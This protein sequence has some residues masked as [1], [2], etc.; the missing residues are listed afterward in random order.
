MSA[1]QTRT[2]FSRKT[3]AIA[4]ASA[5]AMGGVQLTAPT[6]GVFAAATASAAELNPSVVTKTELVSDKSGQNVLGT[7][8]EATREAY[9][10]FY[11]KHG[12]HFTL[13]LDFKIPDSAQPGDTLEVSKNSG[14]F[15]IKGNVEAATDEGRKVGNLTVDDSVVTFTVSN[16][17]AE[18]INRTASF[19]IPFFIFLGDNA[20]QVRSSAKQD[21]GKPASSVDVYFSSKPNSVL[22]LKRV[23]KYESNNAQLFDSVNDAPHVNG[24]SIVNLDTGTSRAILSPK[25]GHANY[26]ASQQND[27]TYVLD[28]SAKTRDVTV[29]YTIDDKDG[30]VFAMNAKPALSVYKFSPKKL[31]SKDGNEPAVEGENSYLY[32][33]VNDKTFNTTLKQINKQ[34]LDVTIHDVPPEYAVNVQFG[35][36]KAESPYSPGKTVTAT[37]EFINGVG[38]PHSAYNQAYNGDISRSYTHPSFSGYG[39]ADDIKRNVAMSAKVNGQEAD[40]IN[41]AQQVKDGKAKFTIDLKNNGNI[42]AAS[43]TVKYPK[44]VTGPNGETEKFIDFGSEGFPAGSTKTLDL[45]ELNVPDGTNENKFTVVMTGYPELTDAAWTA[46]GPTDIYVDKVERKGDTVTITR[47]D[48]K[49]FTFKV[50]DTNGIKDVIDNG[51]G[52]ITIVR[53]NG[54]K[55]KVDLTHTTVTESNKGKPNHTITITTPDGKKISFNAYD[56]YV[57]SIKDLGDGKYALVRKDNTQ[58][59]GVIDTTDGSITNIKP[60]GKGNLIVT[61]DGKDKKVPLD[62]VKITETNKGK[63]NHTITITT[64]DGDKVT[65]NA[66][67]TYVTDIKKNADGN[68]DIYRSDKNGGKTVWKTIKLD[69]L[70][71]AIADLKDKDAEHDERLDDLD[72]QLNDA[73]DELD[74]LADK[75]AN[76]EGAIEDHRKD[77]RDIL[78]NIGNIEGDIE[79]IEDELERL[80]GQDIKEVRDNGDGTYTLIRNNDDEVNVD[81]GSSET[82]TDITPNKDGS[83][84]VHKIDGSKVKVD[85]AK[86]KITEKNKGTPDHTV[87]ITVPGEKPFTFNAYDNHIVDVK[88]EDNGNYTVVRR[89]GES[90]EINLKDIRD[91]ITALE[92]KD[93]PTRDEFDAVKKDLADLTTRVNN[94]FKAIDNRFENVEGDITNLRNDLTVLENRVTKVEARLTDVEDHADAITKCLY[95]TGMAA[96]PAAL[97]IPLA[98]MTQVQIPGVA[99]LNTDIQRQ[100][101]IY[102]ENLAKMWGEYGGVLQAGAALSALAGMIGGLAY[103]TNECAPLTET[104]AAQETDLGQLSSKMEQGSSRKG[105]TANTAAPEADAPK[106]E[107]ETDAKVETNAD[108]EAEVE[109]EKDN[110]A[111]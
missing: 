38:E 103:I 68:Y 86:V 15:R 2:T 101:G 96:I 76:N 27:G 49:E 1:T 89:D 20:H 45:D 23:Y 36:I 83:I 94:E 57:V 69:D 99:Q 75:V 32:Q 9:D 67:D 63:P 26:R 43:A 33:K 100:I 14:L 97:S 6:N 104:D 85:L 29:R 21:D 35:E 56:N 12:K 7:T 55:D 50:N 47:N 3:V 72:E 79:D 64:P 53:D 8:V 52:S 24:F 98:L 71:K 18:S 70:R 87:T 22:T 46:T 28:A 40:N 106:D 37:G 91:R 4:V 107:T 41:S 82:V 60:D 74:D 34:T 92:D 31:K 88:R 111:A 102:D 11:N 90:W 51:D 80:D 109:S 95:G 108:A 5:V 105:N 17:V 19:E 78:V 65:F 54:D 62:Q 61:I 58:V 42:G 48:K 93:S 81:I 10:D 73:N 30:R 16:A 25:I 13:K 39:S 59:E 110:A 44:G 77:I 84:T 66:F